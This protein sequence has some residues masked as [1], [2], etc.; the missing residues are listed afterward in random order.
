MGYLSI[1]TGSFS[2]PAL[3][4]PTVVIM[5][6][7]YDALGLDARYLNCEV[8]PEGLGDAVRGARAMGWAGFNCSLPH[9]VAVLEH[10]DGLAPSA[11]IIGAVNCVVRRPAPDGGPDQLIGENT[12]G[13]GFLMSLREVVDPAGLSV[14]V[15]G[16]GGAARA[17]AVE[18]A[19]A[20]AREVVVVNRDRG[21][22]QD[23]V[24]LLASRTPAAA[25]L[26]VWAAAYQVPADVGLLVDATSV[27]MPPRQAALPDL[28]MA[29]LRGD[30]VVADVTSDP[31]GTGLLTAA[32]AAG[33]T[34][35][36]G[37][38]MLVNQAVL[39]IALWTGRDADPAVLTAALAR[40]S[41]TAASSE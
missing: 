32:R 36:H 19:L 40:V 31:A 5:E 37:H 17:V 10:L 11:E 35:L 4:N 18:L 27:G 25:R 24:D 7:A 2:T 23:L 13:Q 20:G 8:A 39:G 33:A 21:R 34:T 22:G 1:L 26:V 29:T 6:A 28:D 15:L 30:L 38:G 9:K 41:G 14:A 3:D 16:A 12:D